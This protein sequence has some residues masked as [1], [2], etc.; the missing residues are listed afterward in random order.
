M[1]AISVES[2]PVSHQ[3]IRQ[4]LGAPPPPRDPAVLER[5]HGIESGLMA[6]A[7]L[8]AV[9]CL[10]LGLRFRTKISTEIAARGI[11]S[12]RKIAASARN[13]RDQASR[14]ADEIENNR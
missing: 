12:G 8:L 9:F 10:G 3:G 13:F 6:A 5:E 4:E 7:F 1:T 2:L 14:R 11:L